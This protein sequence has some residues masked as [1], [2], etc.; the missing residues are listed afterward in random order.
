MCSLDE[1]K[2]AGEARCGVIARSIEARRRCASVSMHSTWRTCCR[3]A[4]SP[5][6][7]I[8]RYIARAEHK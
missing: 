8:R 6:K 1:G 2:V 3:E 4:P 5:Q 7:T